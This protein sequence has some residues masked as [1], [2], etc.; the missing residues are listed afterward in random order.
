MYNANR[1]DDYF[2]GV[3]NKFI[4]VAQNH[5]RNKKTQLIHCPCKTC[6]NLKVYSDL[7]TIRSHVV[8]S[9]FVKD[10]TIWEH[11]G[12]TDAPSPMNNP[13]DEIIQDEEFDR[14]FDAYSDFGRGGDG[15][16]DDNG[17]SDD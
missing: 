6:R 16:G 10:Y 9:G 5:T 7:T 14:M 2:R 13:L 1:T 17:S 12:E 11:H 3:F 8:V 4:K 15:V